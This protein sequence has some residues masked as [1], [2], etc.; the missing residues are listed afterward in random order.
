MIVN[1]ISL[2]SGLMVGLNK[3]FVDAAVGSGKLY[4]NKHFSQFPH[5]FIDKKK[6][7]TD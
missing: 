7:W 6:R 5:W 3:E 1:L 2:M 4:Y